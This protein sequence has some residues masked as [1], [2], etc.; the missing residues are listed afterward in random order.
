LLN[1]CS[2][3]GPV[4]MMSVVPDD[5]GFKSSEFPSVDVFSHKAFHETFNS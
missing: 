3:I 4:H 5:Q 1:H 2:Q